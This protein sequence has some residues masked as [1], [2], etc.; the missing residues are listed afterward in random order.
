M[1]TLAK[2]SETEK[3]RSDAVASTPGH[4]NLLALW[5]MR[6]LAL[7]ATAV[8]GY[9]VWVAFSG[10]DAAGCGGTMN[11][12]EVLRSK[13]SKWFGLPVSI[14]AMSLYGSLLLTLA[15]AGPI[16]PENVRRT[17]WTAI[18]GMT[19]LAA[20]AGVYFIALQLFSV[21]ALCTW[22]ITIHVCGGGLFLLTLVAGYGD[23]MPR[24][25]SASVCAAFGMAALVPGTYLQPEPESGMV[26][27]S[28]DETTAP[29]VRFELAPAPTEITLEEDGQ[30]DSSLPAGISFSDLDEFRVTPNRGTSG[31]TEVV[32]PT[33][34]N[35]Q[36]P[37]SPP[38]AVVPAEP[39]NDLPVV[40]ASDGSKR[41]LRV[42]GGA[43]ELNA[44]DYPV[45]GSYESEHLIVKLFDYTC[46]HCREMHHHLDDVQMAAPDQIG[47]LMLAVPLNSACNPHVSG[48]S[49]KHKEACHYAAL[50]LAV[51]QIDRA[52]FPEY[53][54]WLMTD[55]YP[56]SVAVA[57]AQAAALVGEQL[58]EQRLADPALWQRLAIGPK[59]Y[60]LA[61]AG[62][63]PKL[64]LPKVMITG[65]ATTRDDLFEMLSRHLEMPELRP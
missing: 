47:V 35:V 1:S 41:V 52:K 8:C 64:L 51:W 61:K 5:V 39:P 34:P 33:I 57:K 20:A 36:P 46:P 63:I 29:P 28:Y 13:W 12:D 6:A 42:L 22:C 55:D 18:A 24:V 32:P 44:Y 15:F 10:G 37:E 62:V 30:P 59:V 40:E 53:H 58:L 48:N 17:A 60:G 50:S 9:L 31:D 7:L 49:P 11:C 27:D 14:P 56:P 21:A 26:T 54:D 3:P 23:S 19:A 2:K 65:N 45:V 43:A 38:V 16:A 4:S 25:L